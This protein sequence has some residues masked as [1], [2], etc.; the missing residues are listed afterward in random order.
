MP[1]IENQVKTSDS[2]PALPTHPAVSKLSF[3]YPEKAIQIQVLYILQ[4]VVVTTLLS[5]RVNNAMGTA[6]AQNQQVENRPIKSLE[7]GM[8]LL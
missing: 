6:T 5:N 3:H 7:F 1:D 8:L 2:M 4:L